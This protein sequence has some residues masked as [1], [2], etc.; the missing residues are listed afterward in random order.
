MNFPCASKFNI[1]GNSVGLVSLVAPDG[2]IAITLK[3]TPGPI[4][5]GLG[6]GAIVG[7]IIGVVVLVGAIGGGVYYYRK[8]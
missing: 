6:A 5:S 4:L 2:L 7:I 3:L 1:A 8:K